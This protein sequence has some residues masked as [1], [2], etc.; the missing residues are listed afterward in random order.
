M[1]LWELVKFECRQYSKRYAQVVNNT[2]KENRFILY[3]KLSRL[4]NELLKKEDE[5]IKQ[6]IGKVED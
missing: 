6:C 3:N 4:Q 5:E 1:D 2:N